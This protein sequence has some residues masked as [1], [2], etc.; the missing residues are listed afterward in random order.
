MATP[1]RVALFGG[2]FNP[3]HLAHIFTVTYVLGRS[4]IDE[5]WLIPT[6]QHV[7]G[8]TMIPIEERLA[9]MET[10]I[11]A[12]GWA[13]RVRV[14]DIEAQRDGP[15]RTFDTLSSLAEMWPNHKFCWVFGADNLTERHRWYRFDDLVARW[16]LIVLGRPGHEEALAHCSNEPWC[17][18]GPT[19]PDVS[20]TD[21]RD[22][23]AGRASS[24][25]LLWLPDAVRERVLSLYPSSPKQALKIT[26]MGYGRLGKTWAGS[27]RRCGHTVEIWNR[28]PID[29]AD[30]SPSPSVSSDAQLIL[31]SVSDL[32]VEPLALQ[33]AAALEPD[34]HPVVLHCAG[35][36][37]SEVLRPL[38]EHGCPVGSLHPLQSVTGGPSDLD[39]AY[40]VF[41]GDQGG[42]DLAEELVRDAGAQF[43]ELPVDDKAAYHAA[44]VLSANFI[45]ALAWGGI[46]LLTAI[47]L[48]TESA[49]SL[50]NPLARGTVEHL[51]DTRPAEALTGPLARG[52]LA[53]VE[54]HLAAL[55]ASAWITRNIPV[56]CSTHRNNDELVRG[57]IRSTRSDSS[58]GSALGLIGHSRL[59]IDRDGLRKHLKEQCIRCLV[60]A[61]SHQVATR[62]RPG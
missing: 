26:I 34:H 37:G 25:H 52:D 49:Q 16:S 59:R 54:A 20:S 24:D 10:L 43:I 41:A 50:L 4:D 61:N 8:K 40:C 27:L 38:Q 6:A 42:R 56:S 36:L 14:L 47:G 33:V 29:G 62:D 39:G 28:S 13:D 31:L 3:P 32:A 15:S 35:R 46:Q 18:P 48:D 2:A 23:I 21:L 51:K 19:L 11:E 60:K 1:T 5:V 22:A 9:L 7:F 17:E 45:T 12:Y 30:T 58:G 44:A 55:T 57:R 53:A